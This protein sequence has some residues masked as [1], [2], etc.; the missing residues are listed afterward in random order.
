MFTGELKVHL[1]RGVA[2]IAIVVGAIAGIHAMSRPK[3]RSVA[4]ED[5]VVDAPSP[6]P[7]ALPAATLDWP[8][9]TS[10]RYALDFSA[11]MQSGKVSLVA[12]RMKGVLRIDAVAAGAT[13]S[14]R[15]SFDGKLLELDGSAS[16]QSA[17][18]APLPAALEDGLKQPWFVEFD[19]DGRFESIRHAND[20]P[21]FVGHLWNAL[22]ASLQVSRSAVVDGVATKTAEESDSVGRYRVEYGRVGVSEFRRHK[23]EYV[24]LVNPIVHYDVVSS[25]AD[26]KFDQRGRLSLLR[27]DETLR[28]EA[29]GPIPAFDATT[30]IVLAFQS[31]G[32]AR[33]QAAKNLATM[34]SLTAATS[35]AATTSTSKTEEMDAARIG[36][37]TYA[38]IVATL[39]ADERSSADVQK[40]KQQKEKAGRAYVALTA[41]LRREPQN[42]ATAKEHVERGGPL[43]TTLLDAMRDAGTP[44]TQHVLAELATGGKLDRTARISAVEDLGHVGAPTE[45]T[46]KTLRNLE[47]D[48][49]LGTQATYGLGSNVFRLQSQD[50]ALASA[51]V[52]ELTAR[53][54]N[55]TSDDERIT[56][57]SALGNA[58]DPGAM[59]S[60][61]AYLGA[62]NTSGVRAAAVQALRRIPGDVA[63]ALI[64]VASEDADVAVRLSAM[65]AVAERAASAPLMA[66]LGNVLLHETVWQVRARAA[67]TAA[68]WLADGA[69]LSDV[70]GQV[71]SGD[72]SDDI[73][74]IAQNA[75]DRRQAS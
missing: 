41:L 39:T 36:G 49:E 65:T 40:S 20:L 51:I 7:S 46:V 32:D 4:H 17:S 44:E 10:R 63:D 21:E 25:V 26:L 12:T 58:G 53:L 64:A 33:D 3:A 50:R 24:T 16:G 11:S 67:Q 23:L 66:A 68:S 35:S 52:A 29:R 37:R 2:G 47:A 31:E 34:S 15:C 48:T 8:V 69:A 62:A 45:E 42:L 60:I 9:G 1:R 43:S 75:L 71:A 18:S 19:A 28:T 6:R 61:K 38:G 22:A 27:S 55:A 54:R 70:L 74:L 5:T 73:R 59:D 56:L 13:P 72:P 14:F 57:L 30:H